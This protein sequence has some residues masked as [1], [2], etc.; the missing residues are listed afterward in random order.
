MP[1]SE[2]KLGMEGV[3]KTVFS[4][5]TVESFDFKVVSIEYNWQPQ[6][7]VIWI[8]ASGKNFEATGG[9][10][11]MSGSPAYI[12]GRL[13]G[14]LSLVYWD[15]R[16]HANLAGITPIESMVEVTRRGM[17]PNLSYRGGSLFNFGS[18]TA[19]QGIDMLPLLSNGASTQ[20]NF[21]GTPL[22]PSAD[23]ASAL[24]HTPVVLP[25]INPQ[26]MAFLKPLFDKYRLMPIQGGGGGAPVREA[27]IEPGQIL[28]IEY[29]RGDFTAFGYGTMTYIDGDQILGF[30]H[31]MF[32]EGNVN[33]PIS[34]GYVHYILPR[35]TRST[36][37]ASP[38]QPIGTLVQDRQ[39]AIAGLLGSHPSYIPVDVTVETTD[40]KIHQV[41][42]E[43]MRH[44]SISAAYITL[45]AW[46]HIDALEISGGDHT[47]NIDT[48]ITIKEQP[49]LMS[50]EISRRNVYSSS[51]SPGSV[52]MQ[53]L[54]RPL[55]SLVGNQYTKVALE[56]VK[57]N[58]KLED[59][60]KTAVIEAMRINKDRYRPGEEIEVIM[61]LRPYLEEPV[62]RKGR[63][64][65]PK[66]A[67]E[68]LTTLLAADAASHEAF[69][70]TRA[71]LNY[72][73]KNINQ[74]IKLLQRGENNSDIVMALSVPKRGMTIQG[75]EFSGLPL[76]AMSVMS[77]PTQV[78]EGGFTL[79]TT[80]HIDKI[81]TNYVI[82]G[83]GFVR[84][85][86]DRDAP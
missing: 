41:H 59:K 24:L 61:T 82:S 18:D 73:P 52:T 12:K 17:H 11:G 7:N 42:Y 27:P 21:V 74:L 68:G 51:F 4:G 43:V 54:F 22:L 53:E 10:G 38:T 6:W 72:R 75:V 2:I 16:E 9:A 1:L 62:I 20:K 23:T 37:M 84:F 56:A 71:P 33:L 13:I 66:D 49:N 69:Q 45:G 76:S 47:V 8:K 35:I 85:T 19:W 67:P 48:T 5:T 39:S 30:G 63:I 31:P 60:R 44:R 25:L 50:R 81:S 40:G 46:S 14:A 64:T 70:R 80:L 83:S 32:G 55:L 77:S 78:G 34:G 58:V 29:A 26:M 79:S 36:K 65:I 15:Q 86:I 57:V 3:A 28:G